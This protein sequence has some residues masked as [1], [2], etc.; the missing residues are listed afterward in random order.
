MKFVKDRANSGTSLQGYA[1]TTYKELVSVFGEP[2]YGPGRRTG[3]K[4]TCEWGLKFEDGT[5]ATIYD[6]KLNTTPKQRYD[7][8]IGGLNVNAVIRVLEELNKS[9]E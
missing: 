1:A 3:D 5:V 6:W 7:W 8:H 2:D 9:Q 4:V